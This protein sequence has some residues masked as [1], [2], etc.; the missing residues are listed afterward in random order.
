MPMSSV[1][2]VRSTGPLRD[3]RRL[4]GVLALA[5][6]LALVLLAWQRPNPFAHHQTLHVAF[7]SADG[8]A[9][10]G[11]DVRVA[12]T[13]VGKVTDRRRVGDHAELTLELDPSVEPVRRDATAELRPR[14]MFEGTGYVDLQPG[15]DASPR[16]GDATLP[17]SR[18]HVYVPLSQAIDVLRARSRGNLRGVAGELATTLEPGTPQRIQ[19]ILRAAPPLLASARPVARAA[20]GSHA[21]ELRHAM[22]RLATTTDAIASRSRDLGPMVG[23]AAATTAALDADGGA[24]LDASLARLPAT[25]ASVR[26]TSVAL[27]GVLAQLTPLAVR[28]RPT[29]REL[30]PTIARVR[31]LLR[32]AAPVAAAAP[33]L[34]ADL[35]GG[36]H[37]AARGTPAVRSVLAAIEPTLVVM[38][39]S[40]LPALA[41]P[42][43]LGTPAYLAFMGLFAGGGGASR[44]FGVN[45]PGHFMRFGLRFLTGAGQPLPPCSLLAQVN[46]QLA[47][48]LSA[49]GGCTP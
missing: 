32:E 10:I 1:V 36:L 18:T 9:A 2:P 48:T 22:G 47:G 27:R 8:L 45:G 20:R 29:A 15:T 16:L 49:A 26:T 25:V 41:R 3:R 7:A 4:V 23:S 13:R 17:L 38:R 31:P 35:R 34:I 21:R 40:L 5:G 30:A 46:P 33:P 43:T 28:L 42:T 37:G 6:I 14:L 11:A 19:E 12:G 24:P 44:P 39:R